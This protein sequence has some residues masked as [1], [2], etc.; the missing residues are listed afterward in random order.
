MIW[1]LIIGFIT[2]IVGVSITFTQLKNVRRRRR[3]LATPTSPIAQASGNGPVEIKGR[4]VP[5]EQGVLVAPF[6]GR[7]AVWVRVIIQEWRQ[8]GRSGSYVTVVNE[9]DARVFNVDDGSG[10]HARVVAE[11]AHM[12]LDAQQVANSGT[13]KDASPH[14]LAF[15][16]SRGISTTS[17][18]GLNKGMRF[19]EELLVPGD[20]LYAL[21]PSRREAGPPVSDGYRMGPGSQLVLFSGVGE[22]HE[23][24]L[25]NKT[26]EQITG[27]LLHGFIG[28]AVAAGLGVLFVLAGT[29]MLAIDAFDL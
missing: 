19:T 6:S 26:E 7:Q 10:Q 21:G 3:I 18:L 24:I 28:G 11:G 5:S 8:H 20:S 13:F 29:V 22:E 4:I 17:W 1:L 14:L 25:T 15:A 16:A 12:M 2:L 27:K 9:T 23:L